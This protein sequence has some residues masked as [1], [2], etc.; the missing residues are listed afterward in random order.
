VAN[1][2]SKIL[3]ETSY[4]TEIKSLTLTEKDVPPQDNSFYIQILVLLGGFIRVT[5]RIDSGELQTVEISRKEFHLLQDGI[6]ETI[7]TENKTKLLTVGKHKISILHLAN[8]EIG[9]GIGKKK[10]LIDESDAALLRE[11]CAKVM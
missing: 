3:V 4:S 2:K 9:C 11:F 1:L 6:R 7:D 8:G 10:Y 5:T